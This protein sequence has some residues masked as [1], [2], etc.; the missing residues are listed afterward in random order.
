[1]TLIKDTYINALLADAS[2]GE[3][4]IP[5]MTGIA[6]ADALTNRM[7]PNIAQYIANNFTVL[8]Q[9]DNNNSLLLESSF[10]ATVWEG[11]AGTDYE[12]QVYV[13]MRGS[14]ETLDFVE[15]IDLASSGLA[16]EQLVEMV[17]W[18][19]R[20]TTPVNQMAK[21]IGLQNI[22]IPFSTIDI[23]N[24]V[25]IDPIQGTGLLANVT[26]ITS[27]NGHSLGG[28]MATA[29]TR[30]FG[31]AWN[32]AS[33]NTFNSAGYNRLST[34]NID[35]GFQQIAEAIGTD[36]G[37]AS[38]EESLQNNYYAENGIN[39][40][41][42]TWDPVGFQQYGERI[43]LYQESLVSPSSLN[44]DN[45][46]MYKLTDL[47]AMGHA[48]EKL[49]PDFTLENLSVLASLGSHKTEASY[50]NILDGFRQLFLG[51]SI[52]PT[53]IGDVAEGDSRLNYHEHLAQ[54]QASESAFM[55]FI[56]KLDIRL[57]T[58]QDML[59]LAESGDQAALYTLVH[60]LPFVVRGVDQTTTDALYLAV[61]EDVD[62]SN[63]TDDYLHCLLYTS[64]SPRD[65]G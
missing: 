37:L 17:N 52:S 36:V 12:G 20:E 39:V 4:F 58:D 48:I 33:T 5:G 19:L 10:D 40:T 47:L 26:T 18:W 32:I 1:M 54:W 60:A 57:T 55:A 30:I 25:A 21:Q 56:G 61:S 42:N 65:R 28:Y 43:A 22:D 34:A 11:R 6:L 7:T 53:Q 2:Y 15:D 59:S 8:H 14:Q 41:T 27:V 9:E 45:H 62:I 44:L 35:N 3:D 13:S 31:G 46:F 49:D 23:E 63:F 29:F 51:D 64:P 16:H 38:F 24:F 50:E